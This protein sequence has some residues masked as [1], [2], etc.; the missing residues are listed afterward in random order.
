MYVYRYVAYSSPKF[1]R[2]REKFTT[3]ELLVWNSGVLFVLRQ[4]K[5]TM[6]LKKPVRLYRDDLMNARLISVTYILQYCTSN[7]AAKHIVILGM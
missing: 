2:K 6:F 3:T 1:L 4:V 5:K 7:E